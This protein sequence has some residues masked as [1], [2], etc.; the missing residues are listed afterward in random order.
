MSTLTDPDADQKYDPQHIKAAEEAAAEQTRFDREFAGITG[1]DNYTA[2]GENP[3]DPSAT[4]AKSASELKDD[5]SNAADDTLGKGYKPGKKK[6]KTSQGWWNKKRAGIAGGIAGVLGITGLGALTFLSGPLQFIHYSHILHLTNHAQQEDAGSARIGAMWRWAKTGDVSQ[7][8]LSW[9]GSRVAN[10][11]DAD[12]ERKGFT[13]TRDSFGNMTALTIDTKESDLFT[14]TNEEKIAAI[15][16]QFGSKGIKSIGQISDGKFAVT[17]EP[18]SFRGNIGAAKAVWSMSKQTK[19]GPISTALAFR[20]TAKR[21]G[22]TLHP[23][24]VL[25]QKI[26]VKAKAAYDSWL[27]KRN[28]KVKEL[29]GKWGEKLTAFKSNTSTKVA[30]GVLAGA[31]SVCIA[32]G[33]YNDVGD[34]KYAANVIPAMRFAGDVLS[35]GYQAES[36]DDVNLSEMG[37]EAQTLEQ[38]DAS[39]KVVSTAED[40]APYRAATNQTGG[41]DMSQ[42]NKAAFASDTSPWALLDSEPVT[43]ACTGVGA[44]VVYG[45]SALISIASGGIA[46]AIGGSIISGAALAGIQAL[47][48]HIASS[49]S[50]AED[51]GA[52]L[53]NDVMYGD[54]ALA[55]DAAISSGGTALS[56]SQEQQL[57]NQTEIADANSFKQESFASRMFSTHDGNSLITHLALDFSPQFS[58]NISSA[59]TSLPSIGNTLASTAASIIPKA[60]A[61]STPYD[62]GFPKYGFSGDDL[63]NSTVENPFDN[64]DQ[65]AKLLNASCL[66]KDG[67]VNTSCDYI[68]KASTCFGAN[69]NKESDGRWGVT[70]STDPDAAINPFATTYDAS[71]CASSDGNWL[72]IRFF[73]LDTRTVEAYA[74][75]EQEDDACSELGITNSPN[76]PA[77]PTAPTG[78][79]TPPGTIRFASYNFCHE[80]IH[81]SYGD[82]CPGSPPSGISEDEKISRITN[83]IQ[84]KS[85]IDG[86]DHG[87]VDIIA[88]Q[89]VSQPTHNGLID[90]LGGTYA[91]FPT[92]VVPSNGY[93]IFF[94]TSKYTP[95]AC[96]FVTDVTSN[97]GKR[98]SGKESV[99]CNY[100]DSDQAEGFPWIELKENATGSTF[101]VLDIHSPNGV[102]GTVEMRKDNAK[103]FVA[104]ANSVMSGGVTIV[105]GDFNIGRDGK[106]PP[107]DAIMADGGKLKLVDEGPLDQIWVTTTPSFTQSQVKHLDDF[108][109]GTDHSPE[110]A[111]LKFGS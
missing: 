111:T 68:K 19:D 3:K 71:S 98:L 106:N 91:S 67:T 32:R 84:G 11:L 30:G 56:S 23:L 54:R 95:V 92:K 5:E 96:G 74:C 109:A 64:A 1:D 37:Y 39:G 75:Y 58:T 90:K 87:A 83:V 16:E 42:D 59:I 77:T 28:A 26:N 99:S 17:V 29:S 79:V 2:T 44:W 14:G 13:V 105:A 24:K 102:Y 48:V 46:N 94:N 108:R 47:A 81:N 43:K 6:V 18:G 55:N 63:G 10:K 4:T 103:K 41:I 52:P 40:S 36:G 51:V 15:K 62:Y 20:N 25:D 100:A 85:G 88:A 49:T 12:F 110:L 101:F 7:T 57:A 73:V 60:K 80:V 97:G 9:W 45:G 89:E 22:I 66:N 34:A 8:R 82:D 65:V 107:S 104:W 31:A 21:N 70:E 93:A 76:A 78:P 38:L 61:A 72:R 35:L 69:I 86:V 27:E 33:I 53:M 50:I